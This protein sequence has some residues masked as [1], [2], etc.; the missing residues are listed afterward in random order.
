MSTKADHQHQRGADQDDGVDEE[1]ETV[2]GEDPKYTVCGGGVS[3]A[4]AWRRMTRRRQVVNPAN[5]PRC[6]ELVRRSSISG[7]TKP[8]ARMTSG[9]MPRDVDTVKGWSA[10]E[11]RRARSRRPAGADGEGIVVSAVEPARR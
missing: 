2:V 5:H 1:A 8:P 3:K 9:R 7:A 10:R 6:A 11:V 4:P